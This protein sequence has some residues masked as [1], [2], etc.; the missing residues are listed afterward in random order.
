MLLLG[1]GIDFETIPATVDEQDLK[2]HM[3]AD[4]IDG[5]VMAER[6]AER[7]AQSVA[8]YAGGRPIIGGDQVLLIEDM[9]FDKPTDRLDASAQL[10]A[11]RGKEHTLVSAV[12]VLYQD[13]PSWRHTATARLRMRQF[14][15]VFLD[16][17]LDTNGAEAYDGPGCYHVEGP[18]IQLFETIEGAHSTILGLPLLPVLAHLRALGVIAS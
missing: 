13:R 10:R 14:S 16:E 4:G 8:D 1:A 12:C 17:Y 2:S 7:K 11:L 5:A 15:D 9:V 18:G 3:R 6:L